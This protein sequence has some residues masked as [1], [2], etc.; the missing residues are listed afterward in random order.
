P[1]DVTTRLKN[2]DQNDAYG[3]RCVVQDRNGQSRDVDFDRGELD[4]L[5]PSEFRS[6]LFAAG[7]RTE[8]DGEQLALQ[9]LKAADSETE[10]VVYHRSGWPNLVGADTPAFSSPGG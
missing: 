5:N 1:F 3:L 4:K 6:K 8:A 2:A 10:I 9:C 7:L